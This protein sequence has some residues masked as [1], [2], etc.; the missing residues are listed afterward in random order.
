MEKIPRSLEV[1]LLG[2]VIMTQLNV[3]VQV[4]LKT[5]KK[6]SLAIAEYHTGILHYIFST[7]YKKCKCFLR[8]VAF[9][10]ISLCL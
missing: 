10:V 4:I 1:F 2:Y 8:C 6:S 5:I 3:V 9:I 7:S